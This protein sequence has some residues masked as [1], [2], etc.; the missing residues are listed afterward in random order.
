MANHV[1]IVQ[2][3]GVWMVDSLISG[4]YHALSASGWVGATSM[5]NLNGWLYIIQNSPPVPG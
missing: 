5:T 4:N 2:N 1:Y 3:G